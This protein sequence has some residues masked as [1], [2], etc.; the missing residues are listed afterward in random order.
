[1]WQRSW[2]AGMPPGAYAF[3]PLMLPSSPRR[4]VVFSQLA[5]SFSNGGA[6]TSLSG[7]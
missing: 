7:W 6:T 5:A 2:Q 4:R 1:M 3:L